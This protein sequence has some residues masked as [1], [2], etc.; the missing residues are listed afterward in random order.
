MSDSM[1]YRWGNSGGKSRVLVPRAWRYRA[2]VVAIG[3]EKSASG[4]EWAARIL[5]DVV[6]SHELHTTG[7][8][9]GLAHY[10][11]GLSRERGNP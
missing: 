10:V 7:T 11:L 2:P 9:T 5:R 1:S 3:D 4:G 6:G 8:L